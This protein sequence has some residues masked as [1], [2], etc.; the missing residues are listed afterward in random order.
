MQLSTELNKN[1]CQ[2]LELE[3]SMLANLIFFLKLKTCRG[4]AKNISSR[5]F[6]KK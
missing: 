5:I 2:I 1:N 6:L 3:I 4:I